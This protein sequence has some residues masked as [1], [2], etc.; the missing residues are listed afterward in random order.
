MQPFLYV[1][2]GCCRNDPGG[3]VVGWSE[4]PTHRNIACLPV[5]PSNDSHCRAECERHTCDG[6]ELGGCRRDGCVGDCYLFRSGDAM[7]TTACSHTGEQRCFYSKRHALRAGV[8]T[9]HRSARGMPY[10]LT[11]PPAWVPDG[12]ASWPLLVTLHGAE[13]YGEQPWKMLTVGAE[14]TVADLASRGA[15]QLKR[16][17][18]VAPQAPSRGD[19]RAAPTGWSGW[20]V[21]A[22]LLALVDELTPQ[23]GIDASRIYLTGASMGGSGVWDIAARYSHRFAAAVVCSGEGPKRVAPR[24]AAMALRELPLWV[25]H[26][27]NDAQAPVVLTDDAVALQRRV[28]G[29]H[30]KYTRLENGPAPRVYPWVKGHATWLVAFGASSPVWDWL[31]SHTRQQ[32]HLANQPL[33]GRGRAR[34]AGANAQSTA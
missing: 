1:G 20:R 32:H 7:M 5:G 25:F 15:P 33:L 16:F 22:R 4:A 21:A 23:L 18:T 27:A 17:V 26:S 14:G 31:L 30:I 34:W 8:Q 19:M 6:Y 11:L 13:E 28:G 12:N 29:E 10:L 2:S 3:S 24:T 9:V